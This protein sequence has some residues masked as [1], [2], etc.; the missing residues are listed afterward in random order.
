MQVE[1]GKAY[2]DQ[3]GY[4]LLVLEIDGDVAH[5]LPVMADESYTMPLADLEAWAVEPYERPGSA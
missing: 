3:I 2:R 1:A 5:V 4:G